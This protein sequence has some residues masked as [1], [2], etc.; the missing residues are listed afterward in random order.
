MEKLDFLIK[1]L[2]KENKEISIGKIPT[3]IIEK[4]NLYRSLCNIREP[5]P[6]PKE[7]L[8][9][10]NE[11][12]QEELN[13]KN[14][15]KVEDI[16]PITIALEKS[17]LQNKDKI[18]LWKGDITTLQID[19]IVNAANSQGLGCF[20]PCHKCIDNAIHSIRWNTIKIRM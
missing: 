17:N 3:D 13:K 1:Y 4:K 9:I 19:C 20:V 7:Y 2:L 6:I 14:V 15:I 8:Q 16:Q 12:L 11:Y 5:K 10:E 18:Y